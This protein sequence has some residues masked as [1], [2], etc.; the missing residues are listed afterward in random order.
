ML[1]HHNGT[2]R[3]NSGCPALSP[4]L[5]EQLQAE[6]NR[7]SNDWVSDVDNETERSKSYPL[8]DFQLSSIAALSAQLLTTWQASIAPGYH[9][10]S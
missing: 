9:L 10:T 6:F 7:V 5:L 2:I 4:A 8:V 1:S 3:A